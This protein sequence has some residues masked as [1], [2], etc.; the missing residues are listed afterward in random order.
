VLGNPSQPAPIGNASVQLIRSSNGGASFT[1]SVISTAGTTNVDFHTDVA[2]DAAGKVYVVWAESGTNPAATEAKNPFMIRMRT[3]TNGGTSFSAPV[4]IHA[5]PSPG[6]QWYPRG[7]QIAVTP[8]GQQIHVTWTQCVQTDVFGNCTSL[9]LRYSRSVNGAAFSA[10]VGIAQNQFLTS[11]YDLAVDPAGNVSV[12]YPT[13][14]A[15]TSTVNYVRVENGAV[16]RT[17]NASL[18]PPNFFAFAPRLAIDGSG[19]AWITWFEGSNTVFSEVYALRTSDG[20]VSF[21]GR[22]NISNSLPVPSGASSIGP[23]HNGAPLIVWG[24]QGT[25]HDLWFRPVLSP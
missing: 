1:P 9:S 14:G 4:T 17:V 16:V 19:A 24:E 22:Q 13:N 15:T 21:A 11:F 12:V 23:D 8:D 2:T 7:A 5:D 18:T 25:T 6:A 3:S 10:P 20:G